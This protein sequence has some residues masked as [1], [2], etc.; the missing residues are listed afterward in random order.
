MT[1]PDKG[2][3]RADQEMVRLPAKTVT[4]ILVAGVICFALLLA[5]L[6][7]FRLQVTPAQLSFEPQTSDAS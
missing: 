6:F 5:A 2:D 4:H 3:I 7:A 1:L